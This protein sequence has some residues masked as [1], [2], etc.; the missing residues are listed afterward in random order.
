VTLT[1]PLPAGADLD[2]SIASQSPASPPAPPTFQITG[3]VG[4]ESLSLV[5]QPITIAAGVTLSVHITSP[6]TPADAGGGGGGGSSA[7]SVLYTGTGGKTL[8]IT[9]V[10]IGNVGVGGTGKVDFSG[11]GTI[12]GR[13]DFSAANTGQYKAGNG[14]NVGPTSVNYNVAAVTTALAECTDL[15]SG[16][17][18]LGTPLAINGVQTID[19]STG[20]LETVNGVTYR[21][22]N[23]TSYK[24]GNGKILTIQGDGHPV[25][26][27]F[28]N[29]T[30]VNLG[31]DVE[32]TG[33]LTDNNVI[34]NFPTTGKNVNL[35]NNASSYE[36]LFFRG[37]ILAP[38]NGISMVNANLSGSI[39]G[40]DSK[41]MQIVSGDTIVTPGGQTITNT[42]TLT[43]QNVTID[44]SPAS[45][46]ITINS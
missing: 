35:N 12:D 6:T 37:R 4:T 20:S 1:D 41:D 19:A 36:T 43:A 29:N 10:S 17:A 34:W 11:P 45:A 8:H 3:A 42:A 22:F 44:G 9:N 27:N 26:F 39:C 24:S 33:G 13:V 16:L 14:S 2:W 23:V 15:S 18:G 25:A 40:G 31:G 28:G 5:G 46:F 30:N 38:N 32:L 21:V 7:Y